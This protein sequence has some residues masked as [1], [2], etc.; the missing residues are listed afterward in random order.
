MCTILLPPGV[1]CHCV[2]YYCHRVSTVTMY[3]TIASGCQLSLCT[4][5]LPPG[6]KCHCVLYCCHRVST[7][8]VYCT[9]ATGCQLSLCTVLLPP[10]VNC[11]CV[12]YC[13]HRVSTVTVYCTTATG[14][15]LSLCTVLLPPGVNPTAVNKYIDI[16]INFRIQITIVALSSQ[17][18]AS[19][20]SDVTQI[21]HNS[22]TLRHT[23]CCVM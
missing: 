8:T 18:S 23:Q 4:V 15:Q 9:T 20:S 2:L 12:L 10:G 5:L 11:H 21:P 13:C 17:T 22:H 16:S 6:V 1:N 3:C 19:P 7:V 14:C